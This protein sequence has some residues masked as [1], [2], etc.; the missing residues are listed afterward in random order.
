MTDSP[1]QPI[2]L[3]VRLVADSEALGA[4][5]S[6]IK[7]IAAHL[8][9]ALAQSTNSLASAGASAAY[10]D[11][12]RALEDVLQGLSRV[13]ANVSTNL[14]RHG[15]QVSLGGLAY[16]SADQQLADDLLKAEIP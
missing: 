14:D 4:G 1:Y 10:P 7:E 6:G 16:R 12:V 8:H 11:L 2:L 5:G 13:Q 9:V 3:F 15:D